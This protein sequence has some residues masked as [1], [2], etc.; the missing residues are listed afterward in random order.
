MSSKNLEEMETKNAKTNTQEIAK[1]IH[2]FIEKSSQTEENKII[3]IK[4]EEKKQKELNIKNNN[5]NKIEELSKKFHEFIE[6]SSEPNENLSTEPF[7]IDNK[8]R[9]ETENIDTVEKDNLNLVKIEELAKKINEFIEQSLQAKEEPKTDR[10]YQEVSEN[11]NISE[12]NDINIAKTNIDELAK[13]IHEFIEQSSQSQPKLEE[14]I[15]TLNLDDKLE[16]KRP[17]K[18]DLGFEKIKEL[19]KKIHEFI[20]QSPKFNEEH[21]ED[22]TLKIDDKSEKD[23]NTQNNNIK[24]TKTKE[25]AK[26]ILEFIEK[27]SQTLETEN[28]II[29]KE[30]KIIDFDL[31]NKIKYMN[32]IQQIKKESSKLNEFK[33]K[34]KKEKTFRSETLVPIINRFILVKDV[35]VKHD[36][37]EGIVNRKKFKDILVKGDAIFKSQNNGI[38]LKNETLKNETILL[39][40]KRNE[41]NEDKLKIN[42]TEENLSMESNLVN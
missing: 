21:S 22:N 29:S 1:K 25:L 41:P 14:S 34:Y 5:I 39:D 16:N 27:P 8:L 24:I 31:K 30:S 36:K 28:C 18:T 6:Q 32:E 15:E 10:V 19:A 23:R 13:K 17:E 20:E 7:I 42:P 4:N 35:H 33:E 26:K 3:T 2:D 37:K 12:K 11:N 9:K 40:D 38:E